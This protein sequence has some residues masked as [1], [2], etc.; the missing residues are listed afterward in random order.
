MSRLEF[1]RQKAPDNYV[2]GIGRGA[3]GFT[4][5]SDIGPAREGPTEAAL[6]AAL[7]RA[8]RSNAGTADDEDAFA[9]DEVGLFAGSEWQDQEDDEADRIF[10]SVEA[11]MD[12]R[13]AARKLERQRIEKEEHAR[14]NPTIAEQFSDA[15]RALATVTDDEWANLPEIGDITGRNKRRQN[16]RERTYSGG[17]FFAPGGVKC[18]SI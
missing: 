8:V 9:E 10:D 6:V 4:T 12:R 13:R 16:L 15:K 2:A 14:K 1:L 5:R 18:N 17:D 11:K 3:T 7:E